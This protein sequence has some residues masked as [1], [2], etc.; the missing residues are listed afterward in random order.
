MARERL[1]VEEKSI[2][3]TT[4]R[5]ASFPCQNSAKLRALGAK[6]MLTCQ[7]ALRAYALMCKR[8][9]LNNVN[10]YEIQIC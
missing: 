5:N 10:S 2:L 8:A 3:S 1:E 6:N 7:R 9:F 4:F